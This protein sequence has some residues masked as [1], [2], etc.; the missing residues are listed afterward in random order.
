[1][2]I[3]LAKLLEHFPD[4]LGILGVILIL[5][6]YILLQ[7]EKCAP[8]SLAFSM[9]NWIGSILILISLWFSWNL[10]SVIVEIAWFFISL[11]GVLKYVFRPKLQR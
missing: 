2:S 9:A 7:L 11:Y 3:S 8:E 1:M 5:W 6:Y 10:A 4:I